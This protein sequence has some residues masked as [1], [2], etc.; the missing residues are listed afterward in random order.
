MFIVHHTEAFGILVTL[1]KTKEAEE[2]QNIESIDLKAWKG[3]CQVTL[4]IVTI[5]K[6]CYFGNVIE[7]IQE[8]LYIIRKCIGAMYWFTLLLL[9]FSMCFS[10]MYMGTGID[11]PGGDDHTGEAD[12]PLNNSVFKFF[13]YGVSNTVGDIEKPEFGD[14]TVKSPAICPSGD[15]E[16]EQEIIPKPDYYH[17]S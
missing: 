15:E 14:Y 1:S 16:C 8:Y 4:L 10:M 6:W 13:L 7:S 17:S 3:W 5:I 12:F 2:Q 9:F 11:S